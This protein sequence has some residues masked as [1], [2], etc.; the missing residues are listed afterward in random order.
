MYLILH[1]VLGGTFE[2]SP[3]FHDFSNFY[4]TVGVWVGE[5]TIHRFYVFISSKFKRFLSEFVYYRHEA[6][7]ETFSINKASK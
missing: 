3:L 4:K 6:K 2:R 7:P 5:L 1:N